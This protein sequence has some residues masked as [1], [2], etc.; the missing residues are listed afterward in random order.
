VP[1]AVSSGI[2]VKRGQ[3]AAWKRSG[4]SLID[5]PHLLKGQLAAQHDGGAGLSTAGLCWG[6]PVLLGLDVLRPRAFVPGETFMWP[7]CDGMGGLMLMM[8]GCDKAMSQNLP[9]AAWD[10]TSAEPVD[11]M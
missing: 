2:L 9:E 1:L 11:P 3:P 8:G 5:H 6:L 4:L 10:D 7:A